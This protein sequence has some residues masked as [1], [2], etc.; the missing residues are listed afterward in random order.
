MRKHFGRTAQAVLLLCATGGIAAATLAA[1]AAPARPRA[2]AADNVTSIALAG[3]QAQALKSML[4]VEDT[5]A[6]DAVALEPNERAIAAKLE[7]RN[8][9]LITICEQIITDA[10]TARDVESLLPRSTSGH[11]GDSPSLDALSTLLADV[12]ARIKAKLVS[13]S[14]MGKTVSVTDLLEMQ[15]LM[16]KLSQLSE[17]STSVVSATNAAIASMARNV[18]S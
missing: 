8:R 4:G 3:D 5:L 15:M 17:M 12:N 10:A 9:T 1:P 7:A 18:K 16:N 11:A 2:S 6:A 13:I 14:Q